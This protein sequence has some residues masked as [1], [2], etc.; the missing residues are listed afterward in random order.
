M[1]AMPPSEPRSPG[2]RGLR[3]IALV[4]VPC[5]M[6]ATWLWLA[7][8]DRMVAP[9]NR[10]YLPALVYD[11]FDLSAMALRGLNAELGR[12]AGVIRPF[13]VCG[14]GVPGRHFTADDFFANGFGPRA[15]VFVTQG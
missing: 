3:G 10:Y 13:A 5:L 12:Q 4:V 15:H 9:P 14:I 2:L 7:P 1:S 8:S 11:E 6:L